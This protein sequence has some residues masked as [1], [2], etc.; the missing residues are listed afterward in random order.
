MAVK[1]VG[2]QPGTPQQVEVVEHLHGSEF[3]WGS[4]GR[5]DVE[6]VATGQ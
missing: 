3:L 4:R 1:Q 2:R 6:G 5:G